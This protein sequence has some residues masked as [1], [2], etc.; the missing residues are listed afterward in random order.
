MTD[1]QHGQL[2][3]PAI[4]ESITGHYQRIGSLA[5]EACIGGIDLADGSGIEHLN[6]QPQCGGSR[7]H[8][9]RR[10]LGGRSVGWI[11]ENGHTRRPGR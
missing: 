4:E 11:D 9:S 1:R 5:H 2:H 8:I 3:A 7:P 6:L 10:G